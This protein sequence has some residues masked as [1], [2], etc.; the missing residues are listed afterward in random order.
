MMWSVYLAGIGAVL[1]IWFP[2]KVDGASKGVFTFI[3]KQE[4]ATQIVLAAAGV[5]VSFFLAPLIFFTLGLM[6]GMAIHLQSGRV[7]NR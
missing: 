7:L 3:F 5:L 2:D 1:G 6:G 4:N